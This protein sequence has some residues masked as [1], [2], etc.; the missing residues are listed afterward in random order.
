MDSLMAL[1]FDI[2]AHLNSPKLRIDTWNTLAE[3]ANEI[4]YQTTL[5]DRRAFENKVKYCLDILKPI[6]YYHAFPGISLCQKIERLFL[7]D[8]FFKFKELVLLIV[9]A[10]RL[11]NCN[12]KVLLQILHSDEFNQ[13]D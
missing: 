13:E 5:Q 3:I 8:E 7:E 10:I 2:Q 4:Q 9:Q 6:E 1:H 11:N 12:Y